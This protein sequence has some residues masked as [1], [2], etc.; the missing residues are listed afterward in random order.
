MGRS[1]L[2]LPKFHQAA[3]SI[4]TEKFKKVIKNAVQL[5]L[6]KRLISYISEWQVTKCWNGTGFSWTGN[7][8]KKFRVSSLRREAKWKSSSASNLYLL[9]NRSFHRV[10]TQILPFNRENATAQYAESMQRSTRMNAGR[11]DVDMNGN[12]SR[13]DELTTTSPT[14]FIP[15]QR[16]APPPPQP[17]V[18]GIGPINI[19]RRWMSF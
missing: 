3:S 14:E 12:S 9:I 19:S 11:D 1:E 17:V 4:H 16:P 15:E 10:I 5:T 7:H 13:P 2:L 6:K 18:K 8:S